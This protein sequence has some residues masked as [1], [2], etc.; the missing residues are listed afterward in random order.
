MATQ[1]LSKYQEAFLR[2]V[3]EGGN[4]ALL[5][6]PGS[7]KTFTSL[8]TKGFLY[9][10]FSKADQEELAGRLRPGQGEARTAHSVGYEVARKAFG[11]KLIVKGWAEADRIK[12]NAGSLDPSLFR[13]VE[14]LIEA[15]KERLVP[16]A[17]CVEFVSWPRV[18]EGLEEIITACV[19]VAHK[20]ISELLQALKANRG[21][22]EIGFPDMVYICLK[23]KWATPRFSKILID[24][25]QDQSPAQVE[26]M[27]RLLLPEGQ[28]ILVGDIAQAIYGFRGATVANARSFVEKI[29]ART[30]PLNLSYR[31][32][33]TAVA[34]LAPF[35]PNL[36]VPESNP[37]GSVQNLP[38][39][40]L[41]TT[42]QA[43]DFVL[44][45]LNAPLVSVAIRFLCSGRKA[46]VVGK[47]IG[48]TLKNLM[49]KI[50]GKRTFKNLNDLL[51]RVEDWEAREASKVSG[52]KGS[53]K[54]RDMALQAIAD[55]AKVF[56]AL[57]NNCDQACEVYT[58]IE[59]LFADC[60]PSN[61]DF[62]RCSTVHKCK[63]R[64]SANVFVLADTFRNGL[65]F[66]PGEEEENCVRG[67]VLSR[68][69]ENLY[70]VAGLPKDEE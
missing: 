61:K 64:E 20:A 21:F 57:A 27:R 12:R 28:M 25:Y 19:N 67:V 63:G 41:E 16:L 35:W 45:R 32:P 51:V 68:H 54:T 6:A 3:E 14:A 66:V 37:E 60:S 17:D 24:E 1:T 23:M 59:S 52:K 4:L 53:E 34:L 5:A 2:A 69:K 55:K 7:G 30:L 65:S 18:E 11:G 43:G 22:V 13:Y 38:L 62:V 15:H 39:G 9:V 42:C 10:A 48:Q 33:Q 29:G 46:M 49:G 47:D 8:L 36:E 44:S 31:L 58:Q 40:K 50:E 56:R 70:L 26:L